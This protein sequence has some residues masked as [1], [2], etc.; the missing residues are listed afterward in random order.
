MDRRD[1]IRIVTSVYT[2]N[3]LL[4][5]L[6]TAAQGKK[7]VMDGDE[8]SFVED[9]G[10]GPQ[11]GTVTAGSE[12]VAISN[13]GKNLVLDISG[14]PGR[15]VVV[16]YKLRDKKGA[17]HTFIHQIARIRRPRVVSIAIDL[18]QG[19]DMDIPFM[20]VTSSTLKFNSNN[21]GTDWFTVRI[22]ST[23]PESGNLPQNYATDP[24]GEHQKVAMY[25]IGQIQRR[26]FAPL[27]HI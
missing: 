21:R 4:M 16:L 13:K 15:F 27:K 6:T 24:A 20:V 12:K 10:T 14:R 9:D 25:G 3:I 17:E 2:S 1:F 22:N 11:Q 5:T 18:A 23:Q 8:A 7:L 26:S 19:L